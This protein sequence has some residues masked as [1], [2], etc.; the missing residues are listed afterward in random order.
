V[1]RSTGWGC[2]RSVCA[3]LSEEERIEIADL[4]Q[5]GECCWAVSDAE[6]ADVQPHT[7]YSVISIEEDRH[8]PQPKKVQVPRDLN[9]HGVRGGT[10]T[11]TTRLELNL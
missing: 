8:P 3:V 4:R 5:A 2:G 11:L 6:H 1:L 9:A 10:R 7:S